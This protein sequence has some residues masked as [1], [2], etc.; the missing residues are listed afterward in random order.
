[1]SK[2]RELRQQRG[3]SIAAMSHE[4]RVNATVLGMTERR[5]LAPSRIA[6]KAVSDFFGIP[7]AQLFSDGGIAL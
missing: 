7:E 2:I 1:M 5:Q 4:A 3:L 6:R